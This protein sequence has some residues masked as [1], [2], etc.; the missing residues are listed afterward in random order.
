MDISWDRL[1][2]MFDNPKPCKEVWEQQFD[3]SDDELMR[4]ARTPWEQFDFSDLWY[5]HHDLAYVEL[6]PDLFAYLFPVC[7]MDWHQTLLRNQS[8]SHGDSEFHYGVHRGQVFEKMLTS[9]QLADTFEFF[10]DSFLLR[11]DQERGFV[12]QASST[13]AYGWMSRFN[14]LGLVM[15]RIDLLWNAWWSLETPGRAVAAVQYLSGLIYFEGENPLFGLWTSEK[16]GGGPCLLGN[17]CYLLD[18]GWLEEN[19]QFLASVLSEEFV[20]EKLSLAVK[21]L[22]NQPECPQ[23]ERVR[24]DLSER[25][26]IVESRVKE[27]PLLLRCPGG[28]NTGWSL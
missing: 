22:S 9:R 11:L 14:S 24:H 12:Y 18:A 8:C 21:V 4:I 27:L 7:L 5:Y 23:A 6:Q 10:K 16:G 25:R 26:E 13:P 20:A 3:Y 19:V 2:Q 17:D 15:P 28:P 1:R